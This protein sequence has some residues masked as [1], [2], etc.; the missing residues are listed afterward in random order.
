MAKTLE[1]KSCINKDKHILCKINK[2][3]F[4]TSN[5]KYDSMVMN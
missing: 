2:S 5:S 3:D 4:I 1:K